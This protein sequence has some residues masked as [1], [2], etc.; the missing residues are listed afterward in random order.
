M[1]DEDEE[2]INGGIMA[3]SKITIIFK[4]EGSDP[5]IKGVSD[6]IVGNMVDPV[7]G[8]FLLYVGKNPYEWDTNISNVNKFAL[9][10]NYK[11]KGTEPTASFMVVIDPTK[12][13]NGDHEVEATLCTFGIGPGNNIL[14]FKS[15]TV[16]GKIQP[17][18]AY[19][20]E[21]SE[22]S[23]LVIVDVEGALANNDLQDNVYLVD[24]QNYMGSWQEGQ[25]ELVT[26][27]HDTQKIKWR[28]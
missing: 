23:V 27:C 15:V 4:T 5:Y 16:D 8:I 7:T 14:R 19:I 25:C 3:A 13:P 17:E 6:L 10:A 9:M 21:C 28:V 26:A 18:S 2:T 1:F 22:V 20:D 11:Y 12:M 24:N